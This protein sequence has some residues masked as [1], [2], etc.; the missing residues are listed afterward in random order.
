MA[1]PIGVGLFQSALNFVGET[2][3]QFIGHEFWQKRFDEMQQGQKDLY[4][5]SHDYTAE[6]NRLARAGL[7]PNLVYGSMSG[8]SPMPGGT[9]APLSSSNYTTP[10]VASLAANLSHANALDADANLKNAEAGYYNKMS[11]RYDEVIDWTIKRQDAEIKSLAHSIEVGESEI[12]FKNAQ[13][14]L[15]LAMKSF[16]EGQIGLQEFQRRNLAAQTAL[17]QSQAKQADANALVLSNEAAISSLEARY[18]ELFYDGDHMK[19]LSQAEYESAVNQ[20]KYT[21]ARV[22]AKESIEGSKATQW[23]DW[24]L[25]ELGQIFGGARDLSA[26][27]RNFV[28][29]KIL[30]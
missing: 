26:A 16:T 5:Y 9:S 21:A 8:S 2:G 7:N 15:S 11:N 12:A 24:I 20:F 25:G 1:E 23:I 18:L 22:A 4:E 14:L 17:F 3:N 13:T 10:D 19:E 28:R 6:M 27:H 30:K 29:S